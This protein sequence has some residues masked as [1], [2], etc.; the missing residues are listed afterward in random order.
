MPGI[1][2]A[3][4]GNWDA[5][6]VG[7]LALAAVTAVSLAFGWR[8]LRQGQREVEEAHRPVVM[9]IIRGTFMDL[10]ADGKHETRPKLITTGQ[11]VLPVENIG[12]GPALDLE[13]TMTY[14]DDDG[15]SSSAR[16]PQTPAAVAG[17]GVSA[18]APLYLD[19][20]GWNGDFLLVI[21]YKDVAGK[22][23]RTQARFVQKLKRY[24]DLAVDPA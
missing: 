6:A 24:V 20:E 14:Y 1:L 18:F 5:T 13:A 17:L 12:P 23:W 15:P 7:T 8:S 3:F 16:G 2:L 4:A 11:L 22:T 19:A 21:D 10:G 9:P